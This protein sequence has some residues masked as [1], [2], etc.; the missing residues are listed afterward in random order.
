MELRDALDQIA[1]IRQQ[2]AQSALY[3]GYRAVPIAF[4][5]VLALGAAGCQAAWLPGHATDARAYFSWWIGVAV[6][7]VI[8]TGWEM[9]ASLRR[10]ATALEKQK[11]LVAI[12]QF[13]PCLGAGLLLLAVLWR[14]APES[15]TLLPGLWAL[16]FGL[17]IFA[18]WRFLPH[19]VIWVGLYYLAAGAATLLLTGGE[20]DLSPWAMGLPFGIGQLFAA[21]VLYWTLERNHEPG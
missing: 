13:A 17:G 3:H 18:S 20:T 21:A 14:A 1:E 4:S 15:L 6:L 9:A 12:S 19:A 5:G 8:A 7:S 10:D 2:V 16:F 11:T